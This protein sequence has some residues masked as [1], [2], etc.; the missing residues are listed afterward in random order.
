MPADS[1]LPALHLSVRVLAVLD[2]YH[3]Y[4]PVV[5]L[6]GVEDAVLPDPVSPDASV[7]YRKSLTS[8]SG[9]CY[10]SPVP[11]RI[12]V[13]NHHTRQIPEPSDEQLQELQ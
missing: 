7:A 1:F 2:R 12:E 3:R 5:L 13:A 6:D 8:R 11:G 10:G 4:H 9:M